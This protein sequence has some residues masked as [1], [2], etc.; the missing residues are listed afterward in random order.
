V[1][2]GVTLIG[3]TKSRLR[4]GFRFDRRAD[5]LGAAIDISFD[6]EPA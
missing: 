6:I 2:G 4:P 1:S 5:T 3:S